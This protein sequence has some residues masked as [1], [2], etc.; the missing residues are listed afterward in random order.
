MAVL[1]RS[2]PILGA[3]A[4]VALGLWFSVDPPDHALFA[5][6]LPLL[7]LHQAEEYLFP[8]GFD[9]WFNARVHHSPEP[10]RP[11]TPRLAFW[12]NVPAWGIVALVVLDPGASTFALLL[13][14]S[15]FVANA[16]FHLL[17]S[18]FTRSYS[19]GALTS[20]LYLAV[21]AAAALELW[22]ARDADAVV[23][24][25]TLGTGVALNFVLIRGIGFMRP[26]RPSGAPSPSGRSR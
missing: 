9:A 15:F 5:W 11:L 21:Y 23:L 6:I 20:V 19:P 22:R 24:A 10:G 14:A 18:L 2:W 12:I 13:V 3:V 17:G 7:M 4:A 26:R 16:G 25:A 8:G 1:Y